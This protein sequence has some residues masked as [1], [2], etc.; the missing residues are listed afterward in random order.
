M[1]QYGQKIQLAA[2]P[3]SFIEFGLYMNNCFCFPNNLLS[4]LFIDNYIQK[5]K[6]QYADSRTSREAMGRLRGDLRDVQNI[7]VT[8]IQDVMARGET[9]E[10]KNIR[11]FLIKDP[12]TI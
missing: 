8:N 5:M 2:R 10:S 12:I 11:S 4:L 3:Y 6:K 1:A 7:M 9:I